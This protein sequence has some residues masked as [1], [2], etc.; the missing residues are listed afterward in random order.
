LSEI[1]TREDPYKKQLKTISAYSV[2]IRVERDKLRPDLGSKAP[3]ILRGLIKD[4]LEDDPKKRPNMVD[5]LN[6]LYA[7]ES[8][9][10][11]NMRAM[12][13]RTDNQEMWNK[14]VQQLPFFKGVNQQFRNTFLGGILLKEYLP[15]TIVVKQGDVAN[16]VYFVKMGVLDVLVGTTKVFQLKEGAFFGEQAFKTSTEGDNGTPRAAMSGQVFKQVDSYRTATV[17]CTSRCQ[18]LMLHQNEFFRI[19]QDFPD[20]GNKLQSQREYIF[21]GAVKNANV[22]MTK[23]GDILV[24]PESTGGGV[25]VAP[26][27]G[28]D[29]AKG[30]IGGKPPS[31]SSSS[32]QGR[33]GFAASDSDTESVSVVGGDTISSEDLHQLMSYKKDMPH[34]PPLLGSAS[35]PAAAQQS[36][37]TSLKKLKVQPEQ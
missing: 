24:K 7:M 19:L 37:S 20:F 14:L 1:Y 13:R 35:N 23:N 34:L 33:I 25:F 28:K 4:C 17:V 29:E 9:L 6:R 12:M 21:D 8:S 15:D 32:R 18:L 22:M 26:S 31:P 11:E 16:A 27:Q 2:M 30:T 36:S 5:V 10:N 3:D